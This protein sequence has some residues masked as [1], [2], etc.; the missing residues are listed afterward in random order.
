MH[1]K[2]IHLLLC[3]DLQLLQ[4]IYPI[5][6][7]TLASQTLLRDW[8]GCPGATWGWGGRGRG[9]WGGELGRRLK[10][11]GIYVYIQL[12]HFVVQQKLTQHCKTIIVQFLKIHGNHWHDY[13]PINKVSW[14]SGGGE[15]LLSCWDQLTD[16]GKDLSDNQMNSY[17]DKSNQL[18]RDNLRTNK[19]QNYFHYGWQTYGT[20]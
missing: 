19:R 9:N 7:P 6:L 11:E 10:R 2:L 16:L 5:F 20:C 14:E 1:L 17:W 3:P 8:V 18:T 13:F 4:N 12:I 15:K